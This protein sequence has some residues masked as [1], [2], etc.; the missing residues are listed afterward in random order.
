[1]SSEQQATAIAS[2]PLML[3][4]KGT[5]ARAML[6]SVKIPIVKYSWAKF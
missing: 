3:G 5:G 1:M 2:V 4:A 6:V